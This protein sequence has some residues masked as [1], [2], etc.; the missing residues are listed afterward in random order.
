MELLLTKLLLHG[1]KHKLENLDLQDHQ[2]IED[3]DIQIVGMSATLSNLPVLASW[4]Q[5]AIYTTDFRPIP[6][7]EVVFSTGNIYSVVNGHGECHE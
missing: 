3:R 5:A 2:A 6:L 1:H 4:L 7:T